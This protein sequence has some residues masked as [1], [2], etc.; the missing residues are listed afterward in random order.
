LVSSDS[1]TNA[2]KQLGNENAALFSHFACGAAMFGKAAKFRHVVREAHA[3]S[4]LTMAIGDEVRDIEAARKAGIFCGA[5][6]WGYASVDALRAH[7]PDHLFT[8]MDEIPDILG[9]S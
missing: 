3:D 6:S 5:V 7:Q 4:T 2:R 9:R 8:G 1:E